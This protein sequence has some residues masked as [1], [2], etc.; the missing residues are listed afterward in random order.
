MGLYLILDMKTGRARKV[1]LVY[2]MADCRSVTP[3]GVGIDEQGQ[4]CNGGNAANVCHDVV[5]RCQT[6]IGKA[7]GSIGDSGAR[8][9]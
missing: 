5:K 3:A 8:E 4:F 2:G 7:E 1:D 9:V 6:E